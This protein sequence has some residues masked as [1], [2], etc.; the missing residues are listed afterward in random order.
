MAALLRLGRPWISALR[1]GTISATLGQK[2]NSGLELVGSGKWR[3]Y[4]WSMVMR[5]VFAMLLLMPTQALSAQKES[6]KGVAQVRDTLAR[7]VRAF[8]SLE[9][10]TFRAFFDDDATV[11]YPRAFPERANG[12][13]EFERTFKT[14]FEQIR[15]GRSKGPYMDIQPRGLKIQLFEDIAIATFHLDDRVGFINRRT[16]ILHKASSGWKIVHLHASEV[17]VASK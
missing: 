9:W 12:R 17:P 13:D 7:F 1:S 4:S 3:W 15:A 2:G 11:F 8:N 10:D 16:I 14:V 5:F 6:I